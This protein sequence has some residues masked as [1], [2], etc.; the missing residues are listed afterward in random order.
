MSMCTLMLLVYFLQLSSIAIDARRIQMNFDFNWLFTIIPN[1]YL[2][3]SA[4]S[5][6]KDMNGMQC[7]GLSTGPGGG[8]QECIDA[9]CS[10]PS[11]AVY[12]YCVNSTCE[13]VNSCWIGSDNSCQKA[14]SGWISRSRPTPA[15]VPPMNDSYAKPNFNDSNWNQ[16][17]IPHDYIVG[18]GAFSPL[19]EGSH[20]FL[21][22][23]YSWYRK[24][25]NLDTSWENKS[26]WI[27]FDGI[28]RDSNIFLNGV[29]LGNHMSGY[30]SFR[31]YID[32]VKP[33]YFTDRTKQNVLAVRVDPTHD[34]GW[35]YEGGGIYRHTKLT[36]AN[37]IHIKPWGVYAGS[38]VTQVINS[39]YGN[40]VMDIQTNITY[41]ATSGSSMTISLQTDIVS[42]SS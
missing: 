3:C 5:F 15:P 31:Y 28:Y 4:S 29:Y 17:N 10:D 1:Q 11:C 32:Q 19:N 24:H 6:P 39:R 14:A 40:A 33:L 23:N 37:P 30:T 42:K 21:P 12:Q 9:C 18:T 35:W 34:E 25:F 16:V 8:I 22:K 41:N 13:P 20:G 2:N 7:F 27:D 26:I 38:N 36:V